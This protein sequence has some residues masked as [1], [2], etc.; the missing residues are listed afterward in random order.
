MK[1]GTIYCYCISMH[2]AREALQNN[3]T[4]TIIYRAR[5]AGDVGIFMEKYHNSRKYTHAPY[6]PWA[7]FLGEY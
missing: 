3:S 2:V 5:L 6:Y 7:K 4:C 1:A